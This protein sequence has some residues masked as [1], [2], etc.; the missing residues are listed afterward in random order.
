MPSAV[1]TD[2]APPMDDSECATLSG[3]FGALAPFPGPEGTCTL[4]G[5]SAWYN[6]RCGITLV[7]R[8]LVAAAAG[9]AG[10]AAAVAAG[11]AAECSLVPM[12]GPGTL[13]GMPAT[14]FLLCLLIAAAGA[15]L[16]G[17]GGARM[18]T[19]SAPPVPAKFAFTGARW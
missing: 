4:G 2:D 16:A 17:A 1:P 8:R 3:E 19:K 18:V 11:G 14:D 15:L 13:I 5:E 6:T 10:A 9:A 12:L 7:R